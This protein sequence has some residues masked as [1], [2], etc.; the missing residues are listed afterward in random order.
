MPVATYE[1]L[2]AELPPRVIETPKQY[3]DI[4]SH[5]GA[6]VSKGRAR[7]RGET[8]L[9][10][11]LALVIEDY[12]RR[13]AMPPDNA[14]PDERLRFLMEHSQKDPADLLAVFGQRSHVNEALTG[15]RK[16]S[17][18]QARKLGRLFRVQPGLFI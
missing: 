1:E 10:R 16:I 8:S 11:L 15:R 14:T 3:R 12:D 13:H 17:A 6:L 7:S 9:M 4:G 5:F 18:H 2:L